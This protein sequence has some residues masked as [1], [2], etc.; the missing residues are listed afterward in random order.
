MAV[1]DIAAHTTLEGS[2][3]HRQLRIACATFGLVLLCTATALA[4]GPLK[5]KT[6][7]GGAPSSGVS[8]G[9]H[10]HTY[11]TG[12]IVLRVSGSGTSVSVRFSSSSPV[13]YCRTEQPVHSQSSR[14][15][16]ISGGGTFK[17]TVAERFK[18]GPGAAGVTEVVSGKFS[19][20]TV[21]GTIRTEAG[22]YCSGV[23]S[24][25]ARAR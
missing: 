7:E 2:M 22:E 4:S 1:I 21:R 9:H 14:T 15:A 12:N 17:A 25:S 16:S 8:E 20:G 23:A 13:L 3:R 11:A 19:G 10:L 24:F 6:Y 5:G 18:S